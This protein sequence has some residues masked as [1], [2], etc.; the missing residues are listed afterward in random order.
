MKTQIFIEM[1]PSADQKCCS[2]CVNWY[3]V[4]SCGECGLTG[5][6]IIANDTCC[7]FDMEN[8]ERKQEKML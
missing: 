7:F 2:N 5:L 4:M 3:G 1:N 6:D 8:E